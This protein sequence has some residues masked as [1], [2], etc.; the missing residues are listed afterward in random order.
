MI[1]RTFFALFMSVA[2]LGILLVNVYP[3]SEFEQ[4]EEYPEYHSGWMQWG[5]KI[6]QTTADMYNDYYN[7]SLEDGDS[8]MSY[9]F[10]TQH[11][12]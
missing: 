12:I 10:G 7:T 1:F 11:M 5:I 3:V 9:Y 4:V 2:V 8:I 6:N